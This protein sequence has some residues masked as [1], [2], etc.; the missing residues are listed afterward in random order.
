MRK[1]SLLNFLAEISSFPKVLSSPTL[2]SKYKKS[3][4]SLFVCLLFLKK[5]YFSVMTLQIHM[6]NNHRNSCDPLWS[7][8]LGNY[9]RVCLQI[10][11]IFII[12][13]QNWLYGRI[14]CEWDFLVA[15]MKGTDLQWSISVFCNK[16]L[17]GNTCKQSLEAILDNNQEISVKGNTHSFYSLSVTY[18]LFIKLG[19]EE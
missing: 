11:I 1:S 9:Q 5:A 4:K 16:A 19:L 12:S 8:V 6:L 18:F 7:F 14:L 2:N 15:S 17:P 13:L 3:K 10:L